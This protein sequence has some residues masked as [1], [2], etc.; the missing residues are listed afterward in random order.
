MGLK[1]RARATLGSLRTL[2]EVHRRLH[3]LEEQ[4]ARDHALLAEVDQR[5]RALAHQV[6]H[7]ES[8]LSQVDPVGTAQM[9]AGVRDT[10]RELSVELT[11]QANQT[12]DLLAKLSAERA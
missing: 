2:P 10:V 5:T 6:E 1:D 9:A 4:A 8:L 3:H 11:E 12:S 7:L